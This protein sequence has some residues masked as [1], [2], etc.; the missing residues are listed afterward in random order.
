MNRLV[1]VCFI[2]ATGMGCASAAT[3][4]FAPTPVQ[5]LQSERTRVI[6]QLR[7]AASDT[8]AQKRAAIAE[9]REGL[10]RDLSSTSY[11]VTR[12]YET[13]PF[14]ALEVSQEALRVAEKSV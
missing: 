2:A 10:L 8:E 13:I 12:V 1:F 11:T 3:G 4:A 7:V 6:A 14:V 9:A 5:A